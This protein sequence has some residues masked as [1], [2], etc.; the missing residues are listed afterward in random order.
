MVR[1]TVQSP[2]SQGGMNPFFLSLAFKLSLSIFLIASVLLSSLGIYYIKK[3]ANEIDQ[4]LYRQAQIPG[5]LMNQGILPRTLVRDR[6]MLSQLVGE[7]VLLAVVVQPDGVVLYSMDS[8]LEGR[9]PDEFSRYAEA[10]GAIMTAAGSTMVHQ[11]ENGSGYL[12][13]STPLQSADGWSGSL[14]LKVSA[15][16]EGWQ[17]NRNATGFIVGFL[18]CIVLITA[19]SAL[20]VHWMTVPRLRDTVR[21][22]KAVEQGDLEVHVDCAKSQDELGVLGRGVN[23]MV[24]ELARQRAEQEH[25][26][27]ELKLAKEAAEKASRSKSEFL[28]NM[29]H[30]I[31]TPMNGVLG[32]AQLMAATELLPEQREY[33]DTISASADNLLK[34]INNILDLSR[35]EM[36]K[37]HLSVDTVD[38]CAVLNEL[39][40]FFTPSV[41]EKGLDL[42]IDCPE[43]LPLVRT[44]EGSLRQVLINLMANAVKFTQKGSIHVVVES[45]EQTGNE[46]TLGFRVSDTGIGISKEAQKIIFQEFIQVDG[47]HTREHGGSGLGLAISKKMVE[48][49]GGRLCVSSEPGKGSAF[50]FNMT[51]DMERER[52]GSDDPFRMEIQKSFD[53]AVLLAEDNKLNQR[54]VTKM[55][56]KM[57]CHVDVVEN[58][59]EVLK[60]LSLTAPPEGRP[61]YDIIFM[62]IQMPVL[63]GLKATSM[64]RAQEGEDQRIPIIAIT[65][66]AMKGDRE[67]FLDAGMDAY[68]SKPVRREDLLAALKQYC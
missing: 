27:A 30:E 50:T 22:L 46:C 61:Q 29:S 11:R 34:I 44:D 4:H 66:H 16:N 17:K 14:Y 42:K 32:M 52:V 37:F 1:T 6:E 12:Y 64:I 13:V 36:G 2:A 59:M 40:T 49:L 10:P 63:D 67:K 28:A 19:V 43:N 47:S 33:I 8:T 53:S 58:G 15:L 55:L 9:C 51:V 20:L 45:L 35:I 60:Q 65:A 25:L 24:G 48:Q 7:E 18:L 26:D 56:E 57:G 62:D 41:R 68:L 39:H 31:R 3:F 38:V 21:C 23:H 5:Q 54:V